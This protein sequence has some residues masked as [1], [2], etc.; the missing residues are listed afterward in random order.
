MNGLNSWPFKGFWENADVKWAEFEFDTSELG[1]TSECQDISFHCYADDMQFY[2]QTQPN[3]QL[4]VPRTMMSYWY[5]RLYGIQV[6]R[7]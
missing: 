3:L 6:I 5:T 1:N 7:S 2:F 4:A